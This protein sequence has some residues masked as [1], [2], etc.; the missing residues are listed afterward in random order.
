M[1]EI[2]KKQFGAHLRSLRAKHRE[3]LSDVSGAVEIDEKQLRDIE[4]GRTEPT[5]DLVMLLIGHFSLREEEAM[6]LWQLAGLDR[7]PVVVNDPSQ[8]ATETNKVLY[9]DMVHVSANSYGV[10]INFLQGLGGDGK[11][12]AIARV[13]M[14]REHAKS[15]I[16]VLNRTLNMTENQNPKSLGDGKQ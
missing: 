4:S 3:S 13:G 12:S 15:I 9:T 10:I 2:E 1:G 8:Y 11:P 7:E 6:K 5:E 16:E 14:S